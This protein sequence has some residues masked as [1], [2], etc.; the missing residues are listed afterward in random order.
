MIT[1]LFGS[2]EFGGLVPSPGS[3]ALFPLGGPFHRSSFLRPLKIDGTFWGIF[4]PV[5]QKV[6]TDYESRLNFW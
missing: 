2:F 1:F 5:T 4:G 6:G 3:G